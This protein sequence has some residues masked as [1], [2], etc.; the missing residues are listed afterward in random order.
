MPNFRS[1]APRAAQ[2][3]RF[4][5]VRLLAVVVGAFAIVAT[6]VFAVQ[7]QHL[8]GI[9]D[10]EQLATVIRFSAGALALGVI[11]TFPL[12]S[13]LGGRMLA[14][15]FETAED[16][17]AR[18]GLTGLMDHRSFQDALRE[19]VARAQRFGVAFTL[20]LLDVDDF[21][22][23]NDTLGHA[24]GDDVLVGLASALRAGRSVDRP[25]RVGGDEFAVIMPHTSLDDAV[26][27][28]KR[29]RLETKSRAGGITVSVGLAVFDPAGVDTDEHTDAE[30]LRERADKAL[31]EAKRRGRG[32]V[33]TFSQIVES[34]PLRTS[35]ATITAVRR[36]LTGGQMGAAFQPIWN[37]DTH[38]VLGY[39]G[40]ARP[41]VESGLGPQDAFAGAARL[42]CVE[43]L[44]ELCRQSVL[45]RAGDLP[46][47]VLL[48]LNVAPEV[49]DHDGATGRQLSREVEDAGLHPARVVIELTEH[50]GEHL[51][52]APV[53]ELRDRGFRLAL[54]DVGAGEGGLGLLGRVR[55]DYVKIDRGVIR[56]A[57]EG[58]AG[59]AVLAAI[60]A[61]AAE[62]GAVVIA[63]GIE[64]QESLDRIVAAARPAGGRTH[65]VGGQGYLLG[66][67]A[68][69]PWRDPAA[70]AWPLA[71]RVVGR[72][73]QESA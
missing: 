73:G 17:A 29:F 6:G 59:R 47:G 23:I 51:D 21:K 66:R 28:V 43:D 25:F 67:P 31:Y 57:R 38:R 24:R 26:R 35:A 45:A 5:Q 65:F 64:T 48:F 4:F 37:L 49:F 14:G 46:G 22:L 58:G 42:G 53:Q 36:L 11:V 50:A 30:V 55:P 8:R 63:E 62:S 10:A 13:R 34:A 18:D 56:T 69:A 9:L 52:L 20:A 15:R 1:R 54:D 60:V 72:P 7:I 39:E 19:E 12:L 68:D 3:R 61:Y 41:A 71:S 16:R 27:A 33:V 2:A 40:L 44:D 70:M 32:E